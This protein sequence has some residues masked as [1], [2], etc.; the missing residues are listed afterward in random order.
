MLGPTAAQVPVIY[1]GDV[2]LR[3][4]A[5]LVQE[6]GTDGLFIGRAALEAENF[7]A[8]IR[9]AVQAQD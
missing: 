5:A 4:A 9:A 1:G 7:A 3:N 2:N 8:L 6:S